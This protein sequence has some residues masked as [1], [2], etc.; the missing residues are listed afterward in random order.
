MK[1]K[2][3]KKSQEIGITEIDMSSEETR[4]KLRGG[5]IKSVNN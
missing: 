3:C 2:E 5:D 1:R 4:S